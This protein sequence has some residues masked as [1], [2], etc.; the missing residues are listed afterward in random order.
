MGWHG[1]GGGG[2]GGR[3]R[4]GHETKRSVEK[5]QSWYS[6]SCGM[7]SFKINI[8]LSENQIYVMKPLDGN[9]L[10]LSSFRTL[11]RHEHVRLQSSIRK[12]ICV[13]LVNSPVPTLL[14]K[15][16]GQSLHPSLQ[17]S[18]HHYPQAQVL[19]WCMTLEY[20]GDA[21]PTLQHDPSPLSSREA[22]RPPSYWPIHH[23][24]QAHARSY[25]VYN[26]GQSQIM[27]NRETGNA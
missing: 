13:L 8:Q 10:L 3:G 19:Q 24:F 26:T 12:F 23:C 11:T 18:T 21:Y 1:A 20:R 16:K 22:R 4:N 14:A 27:S 6:L 25:S 9:M 5:H 2:R 7:Q 15:Q 17:L